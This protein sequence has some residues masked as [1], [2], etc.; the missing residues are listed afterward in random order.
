[1]RIRIS[2]LLISASLI[3]LERFVFAQSFI[4]SHNQDKVDSLVKIMDSSARLLTIS[5]DSVLADGT[6]PWWTYSYLGSTSYYFHTTSATASFD[7]ASPLNVVGASII[8]KAW[9]DSDS[10]LVLAETQGGKS[11]RASNP[12]YRIKASLGEAVVPNSMPRWY[13]YYTSTVSPNIS[14][15]FNIDATRSNV[16]AIGSVE[17]VPPSEHFLGQNYP[18]PFN[19]STSIS[20]T[21]PS[22]SNVSLK[23]IDILGREVATLVYEEMSAGSYSR[24]W[25]AVNMPSGVYF[26]R[27]RAGNFVKTEKMVLMK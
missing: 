1:M 12:H 25:D 7:S 5:S 9:I 13:I 3:L 20:F 8:S 22:R 15:F 10:A 14:T 27:L 21:I 24:Q 23:V 18:N 19:P 17:R 26:Y 16:T 2:V 4:A 6:S 11:F